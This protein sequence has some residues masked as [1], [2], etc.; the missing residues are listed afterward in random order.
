MIYFV[1]FTLLITVNGFLLY[2]LAQDEVLLD[3]FVDYYSQNWLCVISM[4]LATST[5]MFS[6]LLIS[7]SLYFL[8]E[9]VPPQSRHSPSDTSDTVANKCN[10]DERTISRTVTKSGPDTVMLDHR[11]TKLQGRCHVESIRLQKSI[12]FH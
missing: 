10:Y 1:M 8:Y 11:Q 12:T 5:L 3:R 6:F 2:R 9:Q 4:L 7:L